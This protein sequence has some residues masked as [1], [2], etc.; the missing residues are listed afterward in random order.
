MIMITVVITEVDVTMKIRSI[1]LVKS[2]LEPE[3]YPEGDLPEIAFVGRSNV[4]K[5]STINT[6]TGQRRIARVSS[7]PGKTQRIHFFK[8]NQSFYFVD[9]PGYGYA[10]VPTKIRAAWAPFLEYY[11]MQRK[12]LHGVVMLLDARHSPSNL[13]LQMKKWLED[14]G[15][16]TLVVVT[17]M[18]KISLGD[19]KKT[20]ESY[21]AML[22]LIPPHTALPFSTRTG[23]GKE[24]LWGFIQKLLDVPVIR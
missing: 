12:Q 6:L 19:Q 24:R 3:D 21:S 23:A 20:L 2:C 1:E 17:K 10:R 13:D 18:D 5:S 22:G 9:L 8:I 15:I 14:A 7:T 11:L 4:G 16:S